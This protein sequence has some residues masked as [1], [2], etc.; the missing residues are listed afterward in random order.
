MGGQAFF[1]FTK[2][3]GINGHFKKK[4]ITALKNLPHPD[5]SAIVA[6]VFN[7]PFKK[8]SFD[9]IIA[10]EVIEHV[11]D[12]KLF[13]EKIS[14]VLK[15]GGKLILLTPYNETIIYHL[16]VHCNNPTPAN[17]HL[18]SFNEKIS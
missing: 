4:P 15:P 18:H 13:I 17:A 14:A 11:F 2:A 10:S 9:I 1:T 12:P 5:H 6:D 3:G 16:C 7:M 8:N